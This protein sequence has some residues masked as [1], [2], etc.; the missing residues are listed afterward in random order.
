[1][2]LLGAGMILSG[3]LGLGLWYKGQFAGRIKALHC[4]GNMLE[5]L[6]GEVR[7]GRCTLPECCI[8]VSQYL[9]EP[10]ANAFCRIGERMAENTGN[11]FGEV[12]REETG[13]GLEALPLK[14]QDR[15]VFLYFAH[16]TG[17]SDGQMQ[18]RTLEQCRDRLR[19]TE[20]KLEKENAEKSRMAVGLGALSGLLLLL[21]LW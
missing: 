7:Y 11:S 9:E 5:L 19:Q 12:F 10:F 15:E 16:Q 18:L 8:H 6:A 21:I 14:E 13:A 20:E 3:C 4:L 1:M 17:F 2:K